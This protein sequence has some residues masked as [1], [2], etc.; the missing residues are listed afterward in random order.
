M[1][2]RPRYRIEVDNLKSEEARSEIMAAIEGE[3][4]NFK[5]ESTPYYLHVYMPEEER[6]LWTPY[7][8]ITFEDVEPG[9]IIRASIGPSGKIW[10]PYAFVY[11]AI[12]VAFLFVAIYG[13][14]QL[15]LNHSAHILYSLIPLSLLVIGMYMVSF[16]GQKKSSSCILI[17][18]RILKNS[19]NKTS[20][21]IAFEL[22]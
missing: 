6:K 8:A 20:N 10:L 2:L 3:K 7:M 5:L 4:V 9:C 22:K 12:G 14:T 11:S 21:L 16:L 13:L 18:D 17:F 15:S 1:K 19:F